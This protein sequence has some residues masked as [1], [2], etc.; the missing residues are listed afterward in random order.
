MQGSQPVAGDASLLRSNAL[1]TLIEVLRAR[2]FTTIG[3]TL[4]EGAIVPE[5][6]TR[7]EDIASGWR[8][9]TAPGAYRLAEARDG[10]FGHAPGARAWKPLFYPPASSSGRPA[11][12]ARTWRSG[13]ATARPPGWR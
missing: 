2:G 11:A 13:P 10:V 9:E 1:Q 6:V 5:E 7:A 3:P 4:R 8:E 12:R